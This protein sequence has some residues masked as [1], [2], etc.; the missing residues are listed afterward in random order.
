METVKLKWRQFSGWLAVGYNDQWWN[1]GWN[2]NGVTLESKDLRI[3]IGS[4]TRL[5]KWQTHCHPNG[6]LTNARLMPGQA[7]IKLVK[8]IQGAV[9]RRAWV[10]LCPLKEV[11]IPW[12]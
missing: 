1:V 5:A 11:T 4:A 12:K 3:R 9:K 10:V 7:P 2:K 6:I 8:H